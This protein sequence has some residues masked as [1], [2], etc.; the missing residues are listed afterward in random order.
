M[1]VLYKTLKTQDSSKEPMFTTCDSIKAFYNLGRCF[2]II[3]R[4]RKFLF[5]MLN[6]SSQ[7][8][9]PTWTNAS[10]TCNMSVESV[11]TPSGHTFHTNFKCITSLLTSN[12]F[13]RWHFKAGWP[14][15]FESDRLKSRTPRSWNTLHNRSNFHNMDTL[16]CSF[17]QV[18]TDDLI[19]ILNHG[20]PWRMWQTVCHRRVCGFCR[21]SRPLVV[22]TLPI[23]SSAFG[24][25]WQ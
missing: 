6:Q 5:I 23:N 14:S 16:F 18:E 4:H 3:Y 21:S 22:Q 9:N 11:P 20:E 1:R 10:A 19:V 2:A 25:H 24:W 8:K 7:L 13:I 15:P 17:S 12:M